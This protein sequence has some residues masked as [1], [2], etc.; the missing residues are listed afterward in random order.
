MIRYRIDEALFG[1]AEARRHLIDVDPQAQ[2]GLTLFGEAEKLLAAGQ[3]YAGAV[4]S[5]RRRSFDHN[6]LGCSL[7]LPL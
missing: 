7:S 3:G 4:A 6:D 2:L 5:R 1:I